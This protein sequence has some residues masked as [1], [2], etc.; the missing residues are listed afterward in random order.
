MNH[1]KSESGQ[2][3]ILIVFAFISLI[4]V[5]ALAVDG[6]NAYLE[7][8]RTQ[9]AADNTALASALARIKG[10][11]WVAETFAIA[12]QNGFDNDGVT[13]TVL[14]YSPPAS[15]NYKG[16]VEYIQVIIV[17]NV[18][19]FFG[20]VLGINQITVQS[21][22]IS[23][24]KTP[25]LTEIMNGSAV[26]SL[27]PKSDCN[28]NRSFWVHGESTLDISGG[29]IFINSNNPDCALITNGS[30]S[31]RIDGGEIVIAGGA[32]IQKPQLITPFPP[33]MTSGISISYPPPFFLPKVGCDHDAKI[34]E[35]GETMTAGDYYDDNFPPPGVSYLSGGV[36]CV[37]DFILEG[38]QGIQGTNVTILVDGEIH[39]SGN[40]HVVLSAPMSGDHAG[41]L[42]YS[43]IENK[44]RMVFTTDDTSSL[45][46]TILLPGAD[47]HINGGSSESGY[48]SQIIGYTI[49]SNGQSNIVIKYKD[50]QNYD[51]YNMPEVQLVK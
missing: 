44:H 40:S 49:E 16:N 26:I 33:T 47:V 43:G 15:G 46:G 12:K 25:E 29:G 6:G 4:G 7:K 24:T 41:L 28:K 14:V 13:N 10:S 5:A 17:N 50:E 37:D 20:Q 38:G 36:Y 45:K 42:I 48:H 9:N 21:E 1:R 35:D 51:T 19:T 39:W 23:R 32:D 3:I 30:G 27:A 2:A 34:L 18:P 22:A 31:I 11:N 8:R